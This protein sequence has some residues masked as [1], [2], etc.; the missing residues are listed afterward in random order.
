MIRTLPLLLLPALA[1]AQTYVHKPVTTARE[2][3]TIAEK[4]TGGVAVSARTIPLNGATGGWEV[5]VHMPGEKLGWRCIVDSDTHMVHD[6]SRIPNPKP[7]RA[8]R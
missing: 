4:N 3:R 1:L 6:K 8:R 7:P 5:E 2:A